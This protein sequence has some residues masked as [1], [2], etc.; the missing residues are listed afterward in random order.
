MV[1]LVA[2]RCKWISCA[3][4]LLDVQ[5]QG[6]DPVNT[7]V[8]MVTSVRCPRVLATYMD[9]VINRRD[10]STYLSWLCNS[11]LFDCFLVKIGHVWW[12]LCTTKLDRAHIEEMDA[13]PIK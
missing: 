11:D 3:P 10:V 5:A 9:K 6:N 13:F 7:A 1:V 12:K 8:V 2:H 4:S